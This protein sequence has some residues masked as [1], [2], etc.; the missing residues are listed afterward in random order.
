MA[1]LLPRQARGTI[2]K[3]FT[4]PLL[5]VT[6]PPC[7][8]ISSRDYEERE[9]ECAARGHF[10][11]LIEAFR[12]INGP[13]L[14]P[15]GIPDRKCNSSPVDTCLGCR[16]SPPPLSPLPPKVLPGKASLTGTC[17]EA[18]AE[19]ESLKLRSPSA[20]SS[21]LSCR[22]DDPPYESLKQS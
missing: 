13:R 6:A 20:K 19:P 22:R 16:F 14:K 8:Y 1:L 11:T 21:F 17:S 2:R 4:Q 10:L 5:H 9:R 7:R 12:D 3:M 15:G 18:D